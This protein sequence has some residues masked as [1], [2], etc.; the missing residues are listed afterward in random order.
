MGNRVE[1]NGDESNKTRIGIVHAL[2]HHPIYLAVGGGIAAEEVR[3]G[4]L[5]KTVQAILDRG[6]LTVLFDR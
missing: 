6:L 3:Y 4:V 5:A 2:I 1:L